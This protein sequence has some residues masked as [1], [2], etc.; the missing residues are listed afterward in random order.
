MVSLPDTADVPDPQEENR[1]W[2]GL[3][4]RMPAIVAFWD[5]DRRNVLA[6]RPYEELFGVTPASMRGR[7]SREVFGPTYYAKIEPRIDAV[8]AGEEQTFEQS[9]VTPAGETRH[10]RIS[11]L[12]ELDD[13]DVVVGFF[14]LAS[15]ITRQ[16]QDQRDLLAAQS[17][18]QMGSYTLR[19]PVLECSPEFLRIV[20]RDPDG[21]SP[22]L[23]EYLA[24]VHPD[25]VPTVDAALER[26]DRGQG[27]EASYRIIRPDGTVAHV[28]TRTRRSLDA[29]G[30]LLLRGVMQDETR[31]QH[32]AAGL[33]R[34]NELLKDL[35]G[36][37]GH[38]L[39]Q[40]IAVVRGYLEQLADGWEQFGEDERRRLTDTAARVAGRMDG[41]LEDILTMVNLDAGTLAT[42]AAPVRV[43]PLLRDQVEAASLAATVRAAADLTAYAD[44]VHVRQVVANLLSNARRYGEGPFEL[45]GSAVDGHVEITMRDHGEGVPAD[46]VPHL[47]DRFARASSGIAT[48]VGGTGFGLYIVQRL[49]LANNGDVAYAPVEPRGSAFTVTLPRA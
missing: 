46:F 31:V 32:L 24:Q 33:E 23:G 35:I 21:P 42:R 5:R 7:H 34:A 49:A 22:T 17:L 14:V 43:A 9:V 41:L 48:T 6:N 27:Y 18:G 3:F 47:F 11:Y 39:R 13:D 36:V 37:L 12:P 40:P 1:R 44:P 8:L 26:A 15:D 29:A 30:V 10:L 38:D 45:E 25:D 2:Q 19:P 28:H 20:G 4:D 16:V